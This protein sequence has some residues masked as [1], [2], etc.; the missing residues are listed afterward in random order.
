MVKEK[1][2]AL[3]AWQVMRGSFCSYAKLGIGSVNRTI[4]FQE[5]DK[6]SLDT[7]RNERIQEWNCLLRF[8][9]CTIEYLYEQYKEKL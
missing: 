4:D 2:F 7:V 5:R 1:N 3:F 9:L 8:H 6:E